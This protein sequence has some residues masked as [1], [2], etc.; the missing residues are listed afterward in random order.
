MDVTPREHDDRLLASGLAKGDQEAVRLFLKKIGGKTR[1]WLRKRY[2]P[3]LQEYEQDEAFNSALQKAW[4]HADS[5]DS[6]RGSLGGWFLAIVKNEARSIYRREKSFHDLHTKLEPEMVSKNSPAANESLHV[7][8]TTQE[9]H[10][11]NFKKA[12]D[13]LPPMQKSIIL[14]DLTN[15]EPVEAVLLEGKLGTSKN[16]IYVSRNKAHQNIKKVMLEHSDDENGT[17]RSS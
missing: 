6:T 14:E 7:G 12:I 11:R 16:A 2:T 9:K 4:Q 10:L 3:L 8:E 13:A 17:E 15:G 5:F 1:V